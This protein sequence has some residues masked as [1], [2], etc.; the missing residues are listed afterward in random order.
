[1]NKLLIANW[2]MNPDSEE[3]AVGLAHATDL[4]GVIICPP[5]IYLESI[6]GALKNAQLGAQDIFLSDGKPHTGEVSAAQLKEAGVEYVIVG[7]SERRALGETNELISLKLKAALSAGIRPILCVGEGDREDPTSEEFITEEINNA[8]SG[9]DKKEEII[10]AYEP[11]W[12]ISSNEGANAADPD[13]VKK[14]IKKIIRLSRKH[15]HHPTVIYGGS[16]NSANIQS[17][18][19]LDGVEGVLV[20]S[21][22]LQSAE[23]AKM[24]EIIKKNNK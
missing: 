13:Y 6:R 1:M 4:E 10:V 20:G 5:F 18:L 8:L 19:G 3:A 22:S 11:I 16:T 24:A 23:F 12:A 14:M 17:Y 15:I 7:H 9:L 21:V 2:K